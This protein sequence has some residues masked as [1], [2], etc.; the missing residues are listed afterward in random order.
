MVGSNNLL[1]ESIRMAAMEWHV[2][3][4]N[5]SVDD[6]D[7]AAFAAWR[8]ADPRHALA[9]E[10]AATMWSAYGTLDRQQMNPTLFGPALT[11]RRR[12]FS[13]IP[14]LTALLPYSRP[15]AFAVL[16]A[17][18]GLATFQLAPPPKRSA[19]HSVS[20]MTAYTTAAHEDRDIVLSDQSSLTLGPGTEI[21]VTMTPGARRVELVRGAAVFDVTRDRVRPFFVSAQGFKARVVGTVFDVRNNGGVVRL[22]VAEGVVEAAHPFVMDKAPTDMV[23]RKKLVAGQAITATADEGLSYITDFSIDSFASWRDKRLSYEDAPLAEL[24]ADANRYSEVPIDIAPDLAARG[25]YKVT[26]S[27]DGNNVSTMLAAL[28]ALFPVQIDNSNTSRIVIR[29]LP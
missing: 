7:L 25:D 18:I 26:F 27:F 2:R 10:R 6:E 5:G 23:V 17:A 24:I 22:S 15:A 28:P 11:A 3:V 14:L 19:E 8:D 21:L 9:Y 1:P 13:L 20:V 29:A 12:P 16:V 4:V